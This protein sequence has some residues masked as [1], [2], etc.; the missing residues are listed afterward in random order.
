MP[1]PER[2]KNPGPGTPKLCEV[3]VGTTACLLREHLS[4]ALVAADFLLEKNQGKAG[5]G[6][7]KEKACSL[8]SNAAYRVSH[9]T[10]KG[11]Q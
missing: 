3:P 9:E 5:G 8:L 1:S 6:R 2:G 7:V 11:Q 10:F 4:P